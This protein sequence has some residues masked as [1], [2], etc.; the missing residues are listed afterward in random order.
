MKRIISVVA[1]LLLA[2]ASP[3]FAD[4]LIVVTAAPVFSQPTSP[5]PFMTLPA[6]TVVRV[7]G[8]EQDGWLRIEFS[9]ARFRTYKGVVKAQHVKRGIAPDSAVRN[10]SEPKTGTVVAKS[11]GQARASRASLNARR[12]IGASGNKATVTGAFTNTPHS[13]DAH[14]GGQKVS[15]SAETLTRNLHEA[16][17]DVRAMLTLIGMGLAAALHLIW[18]IRVPRD[19]KS[20]ASYETRRRRLPRFFSIGRSIA[21]R[22]R[23]VS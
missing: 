11:T 12:S 16:R 18:N 20:P 9:D 3:G 2:S 13:G 19:D 5:S 15:V 23:G 6:R 8:R 4:S 10:T 22:S 7:I 17:S 1:L 21:A 14:S